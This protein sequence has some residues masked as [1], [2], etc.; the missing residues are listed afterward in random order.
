MAHF[1]GSR[2]LWHRHAKTYS[3][4]WQV[5]QFQRWLCWEVAIYILSCI[6]VMWQEINGFRIWW[7]VYWISWVPLQLQL[8]LQLQILSS[9]D[10]S[11]SLFRSVSES[12]SY[13]TTNGQPTSLSWNQ[14]PFWGLC[15]DLYYCLTVVGF[16]MRGRVC[17]LQLQLALA[18]AVIFGSEFRRTRD[19]ILLSQIWDFPFRC[20]LRPTRRVTVEV[21]DPAS[22]QEYLYLSVTSHEV[23]SPHTG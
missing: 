22:T 5:P 7:L 11:A 12:E 9:P 17:R 13:V 20:L 21:F 15:P 1:T 16:L 8:Q 2:L 4:I 3:L 23:V 19:H 18:S 14:A 10:S 6:L